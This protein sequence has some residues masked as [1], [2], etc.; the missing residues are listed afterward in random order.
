MKVGSYEKQQYYQTHTYYTIQVALLIF[1]LGTPH[2]SPA[3]FLPAVPRQ[4]IQGMVSMPMVLVRRMIRNMVRYIRGGAGNT[5]FQYNNHYKV[6]GGVGN[7]FNNYNHGPGLDYSDGYGSPISPSSQNTVSDGYGSPISPVIQN[8]VSDG[9]GS[10]I[11]PSSHNTVSDGYGSPI[12][13]VLQNTVSDVF[14]SPISPVIQNTVSDGYGSPISPVIQNT[15]SDG[16]GSPIS[17]VKHNTASDGYGSPIS[18]V[19]QDTVYEGYWSPISAVS[20]NTGIDGYGSPISSVIQNTDSYPNALHEIVVPTHGD[21]ENVE[22]L[23]NS[24][25]Y[26]NTNQYEGYQDILNDNTDSDLLNA[27]GFSILGQNNNFLSH[28]GIDN[29]N[30]D[31]LLSNLIFEN[32]IIKA[33]NIPQN[34]SAKFPDQN[35]PKKYLNN[36]KET[37][38]KVINNPLFYSDIQKLKE[39]VLHKSLIFLQ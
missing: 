38:N 4:A 21:H 33:E 34:P 30:N 10:P 12:S 36:N 9:Y 39:N 14:V 31:N 25:N 1:L 15:I 32:E 6:T 13:P 22:I 2:S 5:P 7:T 8:T 26:V 16:Y 27:P 3:P 18:P 20:Q 29:M 35:N 17:P 28:N 11:S 37:L 24:D 19:L 23:L